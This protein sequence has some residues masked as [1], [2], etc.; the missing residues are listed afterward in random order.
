MP[1]RRATS[2]GSGFIID[3][4]GYVATNNHVIEGAEQITV[5]LQD[6]TKLEAKLVGSDPKTDIALLKVE[7]K[8]PM[9]Y[10]EFG[11]S[12]KARVGDWVVAI[13]NPLGLG[14]TVTAG[15]ISA[16]GRDIR[17]GPYDDYIQ[18]DAPI[19]RGNSGGPLFDLNGKVIGVNTAI[20]S[21]SGGS[22]GIGF[23]VPANLATGVVEQLREFGTTR[24]GWLGVQ[25]QTVTDEIAESLGLK[26]ASGAFVAGVVK[27]SPAEKAG[28]KTG[29]IILRFDGQEVPE[30]RRLPR[31]VAETAVG[32]DA[33]VVIW[34]NGEKKELTVKLGEL[35]KVDQ[36]SLGEPGRDQAEP[37]SKSFDDLGLTL[38]P[39][40]KELAQRFELGPDAQG[41]V[42]TDV[43][44]D[45][46]AVEKGIR[47]GDVIVEVNMEKVGKPSDV[48]AQVEEARKAGRRSV[49]LLIE[50]GGDQR[51][52]ALRI[53][54]G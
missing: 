31:M 40:S 34:R 23:A 50:Q 48:T 4:S 51:Y 21:P 2:L 22:I 29:D 33:H 45:S 32:K 43:K 8:E 47:P 17:S 49:L 54:K 1:E 6:D 16:R 37:E 46:S 5:I 25:I 30:S 12:S 20:L 28:F 41:V 44:G 36:A 18:T 53:E 3:P 35:E 27:G 11:D 9:P 38:A 15:I 7:A 24:R 10:V 42:I 39:M 14:G 19:N 26:E 52:I 13:G